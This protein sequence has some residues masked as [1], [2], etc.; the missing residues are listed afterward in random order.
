MLEQAIDFRD[1]S[2]ALYRL[3]EPLSDEDFTRSTL[4]KDWTLN[5]VIGHLHLWNW[6]ADLS[7]RRKFYQVVTAWRLTG[8]F[9]AGSC[10]LAASTRPYP[11]NR[12]GCRRH[13]WRRRAIGRT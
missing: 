3:L 10:D 13:R 9:R 8:P 12:L 6:A 4:F 2:E 5:D 7:S 1:E 11:G